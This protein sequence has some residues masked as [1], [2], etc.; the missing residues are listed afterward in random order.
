[1][2]RDNRS[3]VEKAYGFPPEFE[4][5]GREHRAVRIAEYR[6]RHISRTDEFDEYVD[7]FIDRGAR[8]RGAI[9]AYLGVR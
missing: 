3:I 7:R 4:D 5:P 6:D 9:E 2:T 1:M 8:M